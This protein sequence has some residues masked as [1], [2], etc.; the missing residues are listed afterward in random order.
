M[1]NTASSNPFE[2]IITEIRE[3][4]PKRGRKRKKKP[5]FEARCSFSDRWK[6]KP[7]MGGVLHMVGHGRTADDAADDLLRRVY[8]LAEEA[9][10]IVTNNVSITFHTDGPMAAVGST[11]NV[12]F[13]SRTHA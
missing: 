8:A 10:L 5:R 9:G 11:G 12:T 6:I 3:V 13:I 7:G 1:K 2:G 4:T